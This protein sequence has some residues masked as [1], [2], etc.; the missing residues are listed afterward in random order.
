MGFCK[1]DSLVF[2]SFT[3]FGHLSYLVQGLIGTFFSIYSQTHQFF[4]TFPQFM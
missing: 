4:L 2:P 3:K 1:T